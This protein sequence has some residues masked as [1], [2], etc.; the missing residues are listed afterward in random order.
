MGG[1]GDGSGERF[2]KAC[3]FVSWLMTRECVLNMSVCVRV[4]KRELLTSTQLHLSA[5]SQVTAEKD[6]VSAVKCAGD[7]DGAHVY[8]MGGGHSYDGL[9]TVDPK[10][11]GDLQILL[12]MELFRNVTNLSFE[13]KIVTVQSGI[14]LG[15]FYGLLIQALD[16]KRKREEEEGVRVRGSDGPMSVVAGGTCPTVGVTG[17]MLC[18]GYGMFGRYIGFS[19]DQIQVKLSLC[20][21]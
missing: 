9:S 6:V 20:R 4:P 1:G 19:S 21:I 3:A 5:P 8:V 15:R 18:G 16:E 11:R 10:K 17:H 14:R 2:A 7:V 12:H 13:R